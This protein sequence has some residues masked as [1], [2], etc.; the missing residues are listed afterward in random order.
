MAVKLQDV[1]TM[2]KV[3]AEPLHLDSAAW[4]RCPDHRS[5][6]AT[7]SCP[8]GGAALQIWQRKQWGD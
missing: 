8:R 5:G 6:G 4:V 1:I 3:V 2:G 7:T